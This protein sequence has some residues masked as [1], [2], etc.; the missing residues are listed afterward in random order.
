MRISEGKSRFYKTVTHL[1]VGSPNLAKHW[2]DKKEKFSTYAVSYQKNNA[3][4]AEFKK[5]YA[6]IIQEHPELS[7][8]EVA[9][10]LNTAKKKTE[11][12][13]IEEQKETEKQPQT[14]NSPAD[15]VENYILTV[16]EREKQKSGCNFEIYD[17]LLKKCRKIIP[18]FSQMTFDM[19]NYNKCVELAKIFA[20]HKGYTN[21]TKNFRHVLGKADTDNDIKF[22]LSQ[23]GSFKF[24]TF[25][26]HINE[27]KDEKPDVL[28]PQQL[29]TFLNFNVDELTPT[30]KNRQTVELYYDFCVF[31]F[32][33][34]FSPCDVIKLKYQHITKRK[35][36]LVK[37]KK[38]HKAVEI[39]VN[40]IMENIINKYRGQTK[41]GYVFPIMDD[42]KAKEYKTRDYLF[43]KHREK[44]N[45]WLKSIGEILGTDYDLY[46]Y[47]FRHTAITVALDN[48]TPLAFVAAAAGTSI[49]MIQKHY[50]NGHNQTNLNKLQMVFIRA[51]M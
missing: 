19:L 20:K 35:T 11:T 14:Q 39:P 45:T 49:E 25:N 23:I 33:T 41:D 16:I 18:G 30:Y 32:H 48:G 8:K 50:Y 29:K 24:A 44:V 2:D 38:T 47:V 26:P 37:R 27:V 17:K 43:K 34:F 46:C 21:S 36:I 7:A 1:L 3:A 9:Q 10:F 12:E 22:T 4:L 5:I 31:M 42:E 51:A 15:S 28:S 13:K 6:D 40:P